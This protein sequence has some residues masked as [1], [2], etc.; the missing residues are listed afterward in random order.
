MVFGPTIAG[1]VYAYFM[2]V[3]NRSSVSKKIL[4]PDIPPPRKR[5]SFARNGHRVMLAAIV[6]CLAAVAATVILLV[7]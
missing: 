5:G 6:C 1:T 7:N 3:M 4:K 2:D